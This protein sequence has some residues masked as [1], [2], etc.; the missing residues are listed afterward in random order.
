MKAKLQLPGSI[1]FMVAW[2]YKG[3]FKNCAPCSKK[4]EISN[5]LKYFPTLND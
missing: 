1:F 4:I 2:T 3:I 5:I